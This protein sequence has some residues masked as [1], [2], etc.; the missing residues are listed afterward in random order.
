MFCSIIKKNLTIFIF[1]FLITFLPN[2]GEKSAQ[3]TDHPY[4]EAEK[5]NIDENDLATA[6]ANAKTIDDLQ[7]LAVARNGIIVAEEYYNDA[8]PEPDPDLH[9]MSVT[10]SISSTLVGI[11]IDMGYIQSV[12]QTLSDFLGAE[13]DTVNP[14]LGQRT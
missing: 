4:P 9:V 11:A 12:N 5:Q 8:D 14:E 1:I 10:K 7:G 2:C 6:F 3:L 13:V